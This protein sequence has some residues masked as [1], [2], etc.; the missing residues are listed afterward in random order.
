MARTKRDTRKMK[1]AF[2]TVEH[3]LNNPRPDEDVET[4]RMKVKELLRKNNLSTKGNYHWRYKRLIHFY[5]KNFDKLPFAHEM[6]FYT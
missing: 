6:C 1:V 5:E 4:I 3:F 2:V